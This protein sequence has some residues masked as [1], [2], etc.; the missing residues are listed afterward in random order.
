[1]RRPAPAGRRAGPSARL[2]LRLPTST[3][4]GPE[5]RGTAD[6]LELPLVTV[7]A[8]LEGPDPFLSHAG[9]RVGDSGRC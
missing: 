9:D 8:D 6:E 4:T 3:V 1:M 5:V 7:L 2:S